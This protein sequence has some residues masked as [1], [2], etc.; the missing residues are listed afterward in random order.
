MEYKINIRMGHLSLTAHGSIQ[1]NL[2]TTHTGHDV[3]FY[4][5]MYGYILSG[6]L[7][8]SQTRANGEKRGI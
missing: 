3:T 6:D 2:E 4:L 8:V 5:Q 7:V 1:S